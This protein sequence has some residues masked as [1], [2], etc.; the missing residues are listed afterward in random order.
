M[1]KTGKCSAEKCG[2]Q[3][4]ND[5]GASPAI[6]GTHGTSPCQSL[7][8]SDTPRTDGFYT[9]IGFRTDGESEDFARQLE[10]ELAIREKQV[11]DYY[12]SSLATVEKL[13]ATEREL[14]AATKQRNTLV[15][16]LEKIA[17]M[18]PGDNFIRRI[19]EDTLAATKEN[20][21]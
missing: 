2:S 8:E 13:R 4:G 17:F 21:P 7:V 12:K 18:Y 16:T 20:T 3:I 6:V 10:R 1:S 5:C 9:L 11:S 14:A 19:V 15:E